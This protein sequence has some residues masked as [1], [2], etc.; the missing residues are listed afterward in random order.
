MT[1][2]AITMQ[3]AFACTSMACAA[4]RGPSMDAAFKH[5]LQIDHRNLSRL[6]AVERWVYKILQMSTGAIEVDGKEIDHA[7]LKDVLVC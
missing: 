2:S 4:G 5:L 6:D 1:V 3:P 7:M